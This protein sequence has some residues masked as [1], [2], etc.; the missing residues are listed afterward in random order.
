MNDLKRLGLAV[1]QPQLERYGD[2]LMQGERDIELQDLCE[3]AELLDG[4]WRALAR[5]Q[6]A[7]L[8]HHK[9]RVGVH[10]PFWNLH[11][12]ALDP[13][14]RR[15]TQ[16]RYLQGLAFAEEVGGQWLVLHSPFYFWGHTLAQHRQTLAQEI[17]LAQLTLEPVLERAAE[18]AVTLVIETMLDRDPTPLLALVAS[19]DSPLVRLSVDTGH[20]HMNAQHGGLSAQGWLSQTGQSQP[21]QSQ[22]TPLL[23]H[24]HLQDNDG[25]AD[26]HLAPGAGTVHWPGVLRSLRAT[27]TDPYL[28]LEVGPDELEAAVQW[29]D[30]L[31]TSLPH[32]Q[33]QPALAQGVHL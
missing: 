12:D 10:A 29:A 28:I 8:Q 32:P 17:A 13:Q 7:L 1:K 27:T 2:W 5:T 30:S 25:S 11:L 4:D 9:G 18:V 19:F 3:S 33:P 31:P 15:V 6:A 16:Q 20:V 23:G 14:V 21:A 22:P 26:E 24:V